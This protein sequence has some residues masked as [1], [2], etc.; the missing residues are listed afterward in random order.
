MSKSRSRFVLVSSV[1]HRCPV[2]TPPRPSDTIAPKL[3]ATIRSIVIILC[4]I[5]CA[6]SATASPGST[7]ASTLDPPR[8]A[9]LPASQPPRPRRRPGRTVSRDSRSPAAPDSPQTAPGYATAPGCR[10][11]PAR[12]GARGGSGAAGSAAAAAS[13]G[14]G[15]TSGTSGTSAAALKVSGEL[16]GPTYSAAPGAG[17]SAGRRTW[18]P[19]G[20]VD[21]VRWDGSASAA[22]GTARSAAFRWQSTSALCVSS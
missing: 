10:R 17:P 16:S 4:R 20:Q 8:A 11:T 22:E 6:T 5:P 19:A 12:R 21:R 2:L 9:S 7:L 13:A 3:S 1:H 15:T 18:A 14:P